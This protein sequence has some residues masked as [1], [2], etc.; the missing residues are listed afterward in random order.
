V[1]ELPFPL[2]WSPAP[3]SWAYKKGA[4]SPAAAA[5]RTPSRSTSRTVNAL[6][7]APSTLA[8]YTGYFHPYEFASH[9]GISA[10]PAHSTRPNPTRWIRKSSPDLYLTRMIP[11]RA[12]L[13][14]GLEN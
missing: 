10:S 14:P 2:S 8:N 6:I 12:V 9:S 3:E 7:T 1:P 13:S 4:V 5:P 11:P